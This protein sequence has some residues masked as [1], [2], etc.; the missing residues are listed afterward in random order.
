MKKNK[1]NIVTRNSNQVMVKWKRL[2]E[3]LSP[4]EQV[5][6]NYLINKLAEYDRTAPTN[7]ANLNAGYQNLV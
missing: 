3:V 7:L 4:S 6:F 5:A 1:E 2:G